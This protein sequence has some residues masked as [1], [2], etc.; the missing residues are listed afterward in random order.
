MGSVEFN[1]N[2]GDVIVEDLVVTRVGVWYVAH[3]GTHPETL[4]GTL[5]PSSARMALNGQFADTHRLVGDFSNVSGC[6]VCS[7]SL[8]GSLDEWVSTI[9]FGG[10]MTPDCRSGSV[11]GTLSPSSAR[12]AFNGQMADTH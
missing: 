11:P 1:R 3:P 4:L 12:K 7:V 5:S 9:F 6:L 10:R 2:L 8:L